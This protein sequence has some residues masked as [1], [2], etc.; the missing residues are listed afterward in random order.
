MLRLR[1]SFT[2]EQQVA[3]AAAIHGQ[4]N[5]RNFQSVKKVFNE[6]F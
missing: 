6:S 4:L 2:L 5:S 3:A 1:L